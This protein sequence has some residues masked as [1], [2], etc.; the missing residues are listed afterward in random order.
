MK[1]S[2][3]RVDMQMSPVQEKPDLGQGTGMTQCEA[4]NSCY[5]LDICIPLTK[6]LAWSWAF[7]LINL[8]FNSIEL[9][10]VALYDFRA[11]KMIF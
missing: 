9:T 3:D 4:G 1:P 6:S 5:S 8:I 11:L 7:N 2:I 10:G